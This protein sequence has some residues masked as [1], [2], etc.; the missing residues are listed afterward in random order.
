MPLQ[1][2]RMHSHRKGFLNVELQ[3]KVVHCSCGNVNIAQKACETGRTCLSS[4]RT[5]MVYVGSADTTAIS[6][7]LPNH[8]H[9]L[10]LLQ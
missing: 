5:G 9:I 3:C 2:I 8:P 10:L 6:A 7:Q 1:V 4:G